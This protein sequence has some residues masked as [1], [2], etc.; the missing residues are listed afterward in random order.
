MSKKQ[1]AE[2]AAIDEGGV[3]NKGTKAVGMQFP[4]IMGDIASDKGREPEP[5]F[6]NIA[7][8]PKSVEEVEVNNTGDGSVP[9]ITLT[10]VQN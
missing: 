2:T 6:V 10:V 8:E 4:V 5:Q 1:V 9:P 7:E 3:V